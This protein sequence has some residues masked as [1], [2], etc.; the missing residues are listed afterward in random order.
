MVD[1]DA[2][3]S[4]LLNLYENAVKYSPEGSEIRVSVERS[5]DRAHILVRDEGEGIPDGE[6][7]R[8]LEKFYRAGEE[9]KRES[10]GTGLGLYIVQRL[11]GMQNGS[12]RLKD[13]PEGGTLA[14]LEFPAV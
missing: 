14:E 8:V 5:K 3:N 13:A 9:T 6:K 4:V 11:T 1:P 2:L 7:E 10:K 12:F